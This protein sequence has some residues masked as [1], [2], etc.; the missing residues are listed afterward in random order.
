[1]YQLPG[2][3]F[4]NNDDI[5]S[6]I[7]DRTNS[8]DG[9]IKIEVPKESNFTE[10]TYLLIN[11]SYSD[12][13]P[14][15]NVGMYDICLKYDDC[16]RD[17]FI[18]ILQDVDIDVKHDKKI[19]SEK[20][21]QKIKINPSYHYE[22]A[23]N[24]SFYEETVNVYGEDIVTKP[25][26]FPQNYNTKIIK[27]T[28]R[29]VPEYKPVGFMNDYINHKFFNIKANCYNGENVN[30]YNYVHVYENQDA[31]HHF[32]NSGHN[33]S[34]DSDNNIISFLDNNKMSDEER[35][36]LYSEIIQTIQDNM[37]YYYWVE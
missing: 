37:Y 10:T 20:G 25:F 15:D 13:R 33:F 4:V 21:L 7:T 23:K 18:I 26:F 30:Y 5:L 24:G 17:P 36:A 14:F 6:V 29:I 1:M 9:I 3:V 28:R 12:S 19:D 32:P 11:Q 31:S 35:D 8:I 2:Y 16:N 34:F 22:N 27:Y